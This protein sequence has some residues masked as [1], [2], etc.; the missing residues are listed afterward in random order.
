MGVQWSMSQGFLKPGPFEVFPQGDCER[1]EK[2]IPDPEK[3]NI[4]V[5]NE[6]R[7]SKDRKTLNGFLDMFCNVTRKF[8]NCNKKIQLIQDCY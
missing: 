2:A 5:K 3:L 4:P 1:G 7:I 8:F 6:D